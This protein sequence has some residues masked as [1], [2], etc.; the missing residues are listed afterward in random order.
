MSDRGTTRTDMITLPR[1]QECV[2]ECD[3]EDEIVAF[4][5]DGAVTTEFTSG[6]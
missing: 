1:R 6:V 4:Q 5:L 3:D 2:A